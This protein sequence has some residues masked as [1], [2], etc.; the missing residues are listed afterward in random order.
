MVAVPSL[1][2]TTTWSSKTCGRA[3]RQ[4]WPVLRCLRNAPCRTKYEVQTARMGETLALQLS[5][6]ARRGRTG[7]EGIVSRV[8]TEQEDPESNDLASTAPAQGN[9]D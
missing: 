8:L 5:C 3:R 6:A 4:S 2:I 7:V 9:G 1:P